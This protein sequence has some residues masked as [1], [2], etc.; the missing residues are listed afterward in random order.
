MTLES[1]DMPG[2]FPKMTLNELLLRAR[3]ARTGHA[4][5]PYESDRVLCRSVVVFA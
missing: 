4:P 5:E 3:S 2:I 1:L